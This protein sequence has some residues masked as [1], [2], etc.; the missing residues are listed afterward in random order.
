MG[1]FARHRWFMEHSEQYLGYHE[2][3]RKGRMEVAR[4]WCRFMWYGLVDSRIG[5]RLRVW[6][7]RVH[8]R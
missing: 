1:P 2:F 3:R 5:L 6:W 4:A 8:G 7:F